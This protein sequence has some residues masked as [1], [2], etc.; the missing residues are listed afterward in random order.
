MFYSLPERVNL[1]D[2]PQLYPITFEPIV[3]ERVWGGRLLETRLGKNLSSNQP[4]GESWE[5]YWKNTI[6]NGLYKGKTLGDLI[7]AYPEAIAGSKDASPEFPI[8]IKFLDAQDWLSVQVH[9][10]DAL[11]MELEGEPRGKTECWYI[12]DAQPGAKLVYGFAEQLTAESFGEAIAGGRTKDVLQYVEVSAG[13]FIYVPAGTVH[14]IGQGI[15]IYELQQTS[16]TTYRVYDW[17]RMGLDGKPRQLH[18][19]K[20]IRCSHYDLKPQAK[21]NYKRAS[22]TAYNHSTYHQT[23]VLWAGRYFTLFKSKFLRPS[24]AG[25]SVLVNY[26]EDMGMAYAHALTVIK[27]EIKLLPTTQ[28]FEPVTLSLG[29]SVFMPAKIGEYQIT[30]DGE[31]EYLLALP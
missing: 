11:A 5:V 4:H 31:A 21:V 2:T 15:V 23:D 3:Q 27:G 8:L 10:D 12:V 28:S 13:D 6:A 17:D 20:S 16:D 14:A 22:F 24:T 18:I 19:E 1:A 25:E 9:P 26:S 30:A 29:Q 7:S